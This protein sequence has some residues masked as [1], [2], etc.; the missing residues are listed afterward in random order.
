MSTRPLLGGLIY[1]RYDSY[2]FMYVASLGMGLA[3]DLGLLASRPYPSRR[4][5]LAAA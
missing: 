3:A 1:D 5:E 2:A 4:P